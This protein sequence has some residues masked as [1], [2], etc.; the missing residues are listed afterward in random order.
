M[1]R[2]LL[3]NKLTM[4]D[5]IENDIQGLDFV[6]EEPTT[7]KLYWGNDYYREVPFEIISKYPHFGLLEFQELGSDEVLRLNSNLV[8]KEVF[9]NSVD[10][11]LYNYENK[12][13]DNEEPGPIQ[14]T[15][16]EISRVV[17][18]D[19]FENTFDEK[20]MI[21]IHKEWEVVD[22]TPPCKLRG[23]KVTYQG[24]KGTQMDL[25]RVMH[26]IIK[27]CM[28]EKYVT[29]HDPKFDWNGTSISDYKNSKVEVDTSSIDLE[30]E[31]KYIG[32][33]FAKRCHRFNAWIYGINDLNGTFNEEDEN[34]EEDENVENKQAAIELKN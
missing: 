10:Y 34:K 13:L 7:I 16:V 27:K 33:N 17:C 6:E 12:I 2:I 1:K 28:F 30:N 32:G 8:S 20:K 11:Y 5:Q 24:V 29:M 4:S 21:A 19:N 23:M 22:P 31:F 26:P 18:E 15:F 9:D 3:K 14:D 25:V